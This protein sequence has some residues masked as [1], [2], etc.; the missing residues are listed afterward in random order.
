VYRLLPLLLVFTFTQTAFADPVPNPCALLSTAQ[1]ASLLG[2]KVQ[3]HTATSGHG[4][5]TC[6]WKGSPGGYN[7]SQVS[8]TLSVNLSGK[9]AFLHTAKTIPGAVRVAGLGTF[10]FSA[11]GG[12]SLFAWQHGYAIGLSGT[13]VKVYPDQAK[14]AAAAALKR[15]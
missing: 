12:F 14:T 4:Q 13:F 5:R 15:L 8:V 10:A 7:P 11:N 1:V 3:S 6:T 9:S 2:T